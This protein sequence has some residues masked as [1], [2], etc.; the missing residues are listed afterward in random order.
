MTHLRK[1]D[2]LFWTFK[3]LSGNGASGCQAISHFSDQ[4]QH[5]QAKTDVLEI[6]AMGSIPRLPM[7]RS[8]GLRLSLRVLIIDRRCRS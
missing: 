6:Q 8:V 1:P 3:N 2:F 5:F 7:A 4:L